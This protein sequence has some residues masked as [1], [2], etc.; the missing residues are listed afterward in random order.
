MDLGEEGVRR[1][2]VR[3]MKFGE[4]RRLWCGTGSRVLEN[5]DL[6]FRSLQQLYQSHGFGSV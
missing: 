6:R 4:F 3:V 5:K 2:W 1:V